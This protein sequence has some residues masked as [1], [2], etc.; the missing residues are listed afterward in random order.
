MCGC[1]ACCV[2]CCPPCVWEPSPTPS[3]YRRSLWIRPLRP[4]P[5]SFC[6]RLSCRL[7]GTGTQIPPPLCFVRVLSLSVLFVTVLSLRPPPSVALSNGVR[8]GINGSPTP[9]R[10]YLTR[11]HDSSVPRCDRSWLALGNPS[12][13]AQPNC[14][15][16]PHRVEPRWCRSPPGRD[17]TSCSAARPAGASLAAGGTTKKKVRADQDQGGRES[18]A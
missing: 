16:H 1:G 3:T 4:L 9:Q 14:T 15:A 11:Q 5:H 8:R 17:E 10:P 7:R 12:C 6:I 13:Y 2:F 18:A